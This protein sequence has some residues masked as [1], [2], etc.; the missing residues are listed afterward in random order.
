MGRSRHDG[1]PPVSAGKNRVDEIH[2]DDTRWDIECSHRGLP[3][4]YKNKKEK[5]A[6]A[7]HIADEDT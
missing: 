6:W 3:K 5:A 2:R 4:S 7:S 1:K